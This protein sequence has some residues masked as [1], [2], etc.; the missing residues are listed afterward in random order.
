MMAAAPYIQIAH[1][2]LGVIS[3]A[4]P[5]QILVGPALPFAMVQT[6]S[7]TKSTCIAVAYALFA[8]RSAGAMH[9]QNVKRYAKPGLAADGF[10][11]P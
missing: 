1:G 11:Q 9:S 10:L 6:R 4:V 3:H 7:L 8:L 2:K 5:H